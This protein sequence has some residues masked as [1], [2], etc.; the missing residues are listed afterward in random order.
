MNGLN[1]C[2]VI[3]NLTRDVELR[4]V[5]ANSTAVCDLGIAITTKRRAKDGMK[6]ETAFLDATLWGKMAEAAAQYARKGT[7]VFIAGRLVMETWQDKEGNQRN[8]LK[9]VCEE[10]RLLGGKP[11]GNQGGG[12]DQPPPQ[13]QRKAPPKKQ[14]TPPQEEYCDDDSSCPF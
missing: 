3:G 5:G 12:D 6:E 9:L 7:P 13:Q 11:G 8:K 10:L 14:A 2:H 1:V 4:H